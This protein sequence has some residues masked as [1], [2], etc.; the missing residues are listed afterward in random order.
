MERNPTIATAL[1]YACK[2]AFIAVNRNEN[3]P[4]LTNKYDLERGYL[5]NIPI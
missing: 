5:T 4:T 3:V 2:T 1:Q